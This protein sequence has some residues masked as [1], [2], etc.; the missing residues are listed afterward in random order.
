MG[1]H[2]IKQVAVLHN[3][4]LKYMREHTSPT[5]PILLRDLEQQINALYPHQLKNFAQL[6]T[7]LIKFHGEGK[8]HRIKPSGREN[9]W[10]V[11]KPG[12]AT[13][14]PQ[15]VIDKIKAEA[16][17]LQRK[18]GSVFGKLNKKK[19]DISIS[20]IAEPASTEKYKRPEITISK[21]QVLIVSEHIKITIEI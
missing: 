4:V 5:K 16:T 9:Y 7:A 3:I 11:S 21:N 2:A 19:E 8:V 6:N 13:Q 17:E 18:Q 14:P 20:T 12:E 15:E 10:W 1:N